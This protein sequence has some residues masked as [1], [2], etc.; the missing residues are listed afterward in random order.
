MDDFQ[1]RSEAIYQ[2]SVGDFIENAFYLGKRYEDMGSHF[3]DVDNFSG[4]IKFVG[5]ESSGIYPQWGY[6]NRD[7]SPCYLTIQIYKSEWPKVKRGWG[8]LKHFLKIAGGPPG[9]P[10]P[11]A[12][13]KTDISAG[14]TNRFGGPLSSYPPEKIWSVY[15]EWEK[16]KRRGDR[17][18]TKELWLEE[19]LPGLSVGGFEKSV[20]KIQK[21][22]NGI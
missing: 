10:L 11:P 9:I 8:V 22:R 2:G 15:L 16:Y 4:T 14:K 21:S 18:K 3:W 1:E 19:K 12:E 13:K 20:R 5:A 6:I 7:T 17:D